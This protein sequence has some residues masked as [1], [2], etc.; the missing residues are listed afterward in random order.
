MAHIFIN[1]F[2]FKNVNFLLI[3]IV[4]LLLV[5]TSAEIQRRYVYSQ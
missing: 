5:E 1:K 3:T 4:L 2:A